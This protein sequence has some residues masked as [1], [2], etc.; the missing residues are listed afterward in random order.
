VIDSADATGSRLVG[1]NAVK[2]AEEKQSIDI[3]RVLMQLDERLA[4]IEI[5][6]S[7]GKESDFSKEWYTVSEAAEILGKAP[8]TVRE[9]ARLDRINA[10]KRPCGRSTASEWMISHKEIERIKNKGLLPRGL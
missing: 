5:A 7:E 10:M 3:A 6:L 8:F 2:P 1:G 9:W 4:R